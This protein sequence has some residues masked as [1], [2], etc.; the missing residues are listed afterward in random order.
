MLLKTKV[1]FID[2]IYQK[3]LQIITGFGKT[4]YK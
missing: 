1:T 2:A 3:Y 4:N